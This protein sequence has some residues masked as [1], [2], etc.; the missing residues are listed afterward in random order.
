MQ[1]KTIRPE[2]GNWDRDL[3][4]IYSGGYIPNFRPLPIPADMQ[5]QDSI[6]EWQNAMRSHQQ[7]NMINQRNA[8]ADARYEFGLA[9]EAERQARIEAALGKVSSMFANR[10]PIY[11]NYANDTFNLSKVALDD[12]QS[13]QA[14]QLKFALARSGL[15]GG[16]SDIDKA[17]ELA[18][19]YSFGINQARGYADA[20]ADQLRS[21]DASIKSSLLGLASTGAVGGGEIGGYAQQALQ[22]VDTTPTAMQNPGQFY[23]GL[24]DQIGGAGGGAPVAGN[25][26]MAGSGSSTFRPTAGGVGF[27]GTVS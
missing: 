9:Q 23:V 10:D 20:Q 6:A 11:R 19:K 5:G 27:Q 13:R 1:P 4:T 25:P 22:A 7:Q 15:S 2:Y 12:E 21:Q 24:F 8:I 17:A 14:Q 18:N 26:Y 16:S 3:N